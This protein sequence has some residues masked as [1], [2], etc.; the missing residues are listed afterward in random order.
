M[1][2]ILISIFLLALVGLTGQ[3][4]SASNGHD[5][6]IGHDKPAVKSPFHQTGPKKSLH[7]LLND[8]LLSKPCPH[9]LRAGSSASKPRGLAL[10]QECGGRESADFPA[11]QTVSKSSSTLDVMGFH[12][13]VKESSLRL[14]A[15][16][17]YEPLFT[18]K[19]TPP[20]K[21]S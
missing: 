5:H 14:F 16:L 9:F 20:P 19:S 13:H 6:S 18:A 10:S 7:C 17:F 12:L 8:H 21:S 4:A 1:R 2:M 3:T 11:Y 15:D